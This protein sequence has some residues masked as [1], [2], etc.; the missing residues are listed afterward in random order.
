[1]PT[2]K[3]NIKWQKEKYT[4]VECN[5]DE[6]PETFK[7]M[8]FSLTGVPPD[9]QKVMM[10]GK[11]LGD[12]SFD[13]IKLKDGATIMMMGS[14]EV[15]PE[16][17][18]ASEQKK[19][20]KVVV[21]DSQELLPIGLNNLGNTCY[22]NAVVQVLY[23]VHELRATLKIIEKMPATSD[24]ALPKQLCQIYN[25]LGSSDRSVIPISFVSTVHR[26][27]PQFA[28]RQNGGE[29]PKADSGFGSLIAGIYDG[30]FQQQDANE[31]WMS[32]MR[33]LQSASISETAIASVSNLPDSLGKTG[34]WNPIDRF[35][36][37]MFKCSL[38]CVENNEETASSFVETFNQLSC[39]INQD[40][41]Y[42][43]TGLRNS[44]ETTLTKH[45]E[46]LG[47]DA[48][49]KKTNCISRLPAFLSIQFVR[50]FYKEKEKINA[51][52]LKNVAFP[53]TLDLYEF[54]TQE[55]KQKLEP[56]RER[57]LQEKERAVFAAPKSKK[58][59][60]K[61]DKGPDANEK[62]ELFEPYWFED[63]LGSN[64][65]GQY[66]LQAVLTHQGRSSNSG[67]YVGWAKHKGDWYKFDDDTV[68][69]VTEDQIK[70][71]AGGGDWH[72][73][74]VLL[75]GPERIPKVPMAKE[76]TPMEL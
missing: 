20:D 35:F 12:S 40:V 33:T 41:K 8:L 64:N 44:F 24:L 23:T 14:A 66:E 7:A 73:A 67:H 22:M 55:L 4:D 65:S 47:K 25:Q 11:I 53:M 18:A 68:S 19:E 70:A 69:H 63:D 61:E 16:Q 5:T 58:P 62:P 52:I 30:G 57:S 6:S 32:L 56:M 37:G 54:C 39:F 71:L 48:E 27:F 21:K 76:E 50:F 36:T 10:P 42:L 34:G 17:K 46:S 3:V 49:Y 31:F 75:Y 60:A 43:H 59:G 74:Y 51:K 9:R 15:V 29:N 28:V 45:S 26:L 38:K 13:G 1:M 72:C 2:F